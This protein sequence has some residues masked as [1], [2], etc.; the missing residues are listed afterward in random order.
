[1]SYLQHLPE[2]VANLIRTR[3]LAE[4]ATVSTAGVPI[5]TPLVTFTSADLETI[6]AGT[7]LAYPVKAERARR[8]PK[9][10]LLFE[11]AA[12]QPVVSITGVAA[13]RDADFQANLDRY[14]AEEILAPF[15]NPERVDYESVTRQ[16]IWY[17]TRILICVK[18]AHVRW[19][20]HPAAVDQTPEEWR[21]PADTVYPRSDPAPP[22]EPSRAPWRE[23]APWRGLAASAL[24]RKAPG[25]L[26]LLDAEGFPLPIRAREVHAHPDGF[27]LVLPKWLPW[28][29]GKATLSFQGVETLVGDVGIEG[30]VGLLRVERAMP[31]LPMMADLSE[32]LQPKPATKA[33]LMARLHYELRRR[34]QRFPRHAGAA[35]RTEHSARGFAPVQLSLIGGSVRR[36]TSAG[37]GR[38]RLRGFVSRCGRGLSCP[39]RWRNLET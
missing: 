16:A 34:E 19:W 9:V 18:P 7:G 15:I 1:M 38:R 30:S 10:G 37:V 33:A 22:G 11:G 6:D 2:P 20:R 25:H 13:V 36:A 23:A 27:R 12:D 8:N 28:S 39:I 4:F 21:A 31:V 14:L 5:N 35:A 17:F 26:T 3:F 29:G 32:V 24:A